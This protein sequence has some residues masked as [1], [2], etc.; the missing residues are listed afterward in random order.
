MSIR[1]SS[2][3]SRKPISTSCSKPA[4]RS[5]TKKT[6]A[7]KARKPIRG[8]C[9]G[10]VRQDSFEVSKRRSPKPTYGGSSS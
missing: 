7:A 1:K 9:F 6:A 3:S 2:L 8:S 5:K 10:A 4:Q